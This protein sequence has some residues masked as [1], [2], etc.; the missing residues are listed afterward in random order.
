MRIS[1]ELV[2]RRM[3]YPTTTIYAG[4]D[5]TGLGCVKNWTPSAETVTPVSSPY[6]PFKFGLIP[7]HDAAGHGP[8]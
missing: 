1:V 4:F 5:H 7:L 8:V 3:R 6:A 2:P